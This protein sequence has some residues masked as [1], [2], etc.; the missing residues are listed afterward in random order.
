VHTQYDMAIWL[1]VIPRTILNRAAANPIPPATCAESVFFKG[2]PVECLVAM[3]KGALRLVWYRGNV[4]NTTAVAVRKG[5][6]GSGGR[7]VYSVTYDDGDEEDDIPEALIRPA[8]PCTF[9]VGQAVWARYTN[10]A[11]KVYCNAFYGAKVKYCGTGTE[12]E[13]AHGP[14]F[15]VTWDD[16]DEWDPVLSRDDLRQQDP[17]Q[18]E[19]DEKL[20]KDYDQ[21]SNPTKFSL[22]KLAPTQTSIRGVRRNTNAPMFPEPHV[23]YITTEAKKK[24]KKKIDDETQETQ[25][26]DEAQDEARGV[27]QSKKAK[28]Y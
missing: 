24:K 11:N 14:E 3:K 26:Q 19:N 8:L 13:T 18:E 15:R 25:S 7:H 27:G 16:S 5:A 23:H 10:E 1:Q 2:Q 17:V 28:K 20:L 4:T 12:C 9:T 22:E 6:K 21:A